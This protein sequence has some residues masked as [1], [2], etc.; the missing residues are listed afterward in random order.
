MLTLDEVHCE[1]FRLLRKCRVAI[2]KGLVLIHGVNE[3][4]PGT[5]SN[6]AG[7]STLLHALTWALYG[8]DSTGTPITGSAIHNKEDYCKV[9]CRFRKEDGRTID[10]WRKRY[11]KPGPGVPTVQINLAL[12]PETPHHIAKSYCG[13]PETI[14]PRINALFGSQDLFLAAHVF[15]CGEK[16]VPFALKTDKQQKQLFDLLLSAEDLDAAFFRTKDELDQNRQQEKEL[17]ET[18]SNV[19][20]Q[21]KLN[22]ESKDQHSDL[23]EA[24]VQNLQLELAALCNRLS[25]AETKFKKTRAMLGIIRN[26]RILYE[27]KERE[28]QEKFHGVEEQQIQYTTALGRAKT[29]IATILRMNQCPTC[30]ADV[31]NEAKNSL[32]APHKEKMGAL[33]KKLGTLPD[34]FRLEKERNKLENAVKIARAQEIKI[35]KSNSDVSLELSIVTASRKQK[36]RE[37]EAFRT[38]QNARQKHDQ[39]KGVLLFMKEL[40]LQ[41]EI[42]NL[43]RQIKDLEFWLEGFGRSGIRAYRLDKITPILNSLAVGHSDTL[44]GDGSRVS[45]STQRQLQSG[46]YRD[47]FSVEIMDRQ[48]NKE[49]SPSSGQAMRRNL[50]H[51]FSVVQLATHLQKRTVRFLAFDEAFRTLDQTGTA[52]VMSVLHRLLGE[53]D[54]IF[55]IEHNSD[56]QAQFDT[57]LTVAR[58]GNKSTI[59][60]EEG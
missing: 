47:K 23:D 15:G 8:C 12:Q 19:G 32:V 33:R 10:I 50:V 34:T 48:G 53:A 40:H 60:I 27:K 21:R 3:D 6:M 39:H 46:E 11:R 1:N 20:A 17:R 45:Y 57:V 7:K 56:L 29:D 30:G 14:Q 43:M 38:N 55:V 59:V 41:E 31:S 42:E 18:W 54:S 51:M 37:L 16:D 26:R 49:E 24:H 36:E 44:F 13:S 52:R 22:A 9:S 4:V 28:A 2:P 35:E 5:D 58:K 25:I